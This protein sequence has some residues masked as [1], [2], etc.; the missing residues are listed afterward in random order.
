MLTS[1]DSARLGFFS[2]ANILQIAD[3]V[4]E[5]S[6]CCSCHV[7]SYYLAYIYS[8]F[9]LLKRVKCPPFLFP[10]FVPRSSRL[11]DRSSFIAGE[12]AED[13]RL[14]KG[15]F[16]QSPLSILLHLSD[17]PQKLLMTF[18]IPPTCLHFPSKFEWFPV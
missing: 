10:Q 15:K 1:I 3:V 17:P 13:L 4:F 8:Y 12:G 18:A 2:P 16:R 5:L 6:S 14:H 9:L 11:T 7:F